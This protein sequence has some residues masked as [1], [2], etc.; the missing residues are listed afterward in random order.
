MDKDSLGIEAYEEA[1]VNMT[2]YN[3]PFYKD[4]VFYMHL[5]SGCRVHYDKDM[6]APAGVS[7]HND[8]YVLHLNPLEVIQEGV[9]TDTGEKVVITGFTKNMPLAHRIGILKHEMSHISNG[10]LIRVEDRD[11][12]DFNY[13]SD[14][15][16][17]QD[18]ERTHLP[19]YAIYPDNLFADSNVVWG[20]T[21][22]TYYDMIQKEKEDKPDQPNKNSKNSSNGDG[23]G[24]GDGDG[25][26]LVDDHDTWK[27]STG[28]S[29]LQKEITKKLVEDAAKQTTKNKGNL[30][31]NYSSMI[32]NLTINREIDWVK[33]LR[34]ITGNKKASIRKTIM[35]KDR[36]LPNFSWIK[37]RT[38]KRVFELAVV[39][40]V[41]GSM[42]ND[43]LVEVWGEVLSIC[44]TYKISVTLVQVDAQ[45]Y[46]PQE[47]NKNTKKIERKATGG[48]YL[49]PALDKLKER[50]IKYDALVVTTDGH[51]FNNDIDSFIECKVP[52]IWVVESSGKLMD[53]MNSGKMVGVKLKNKKSN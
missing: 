15:A 31:S 24:D 6:K 48:T 29:S 40:D 17:N 12:R 47:L 52:V 25:E 46:E 9:N 22:E 42:G 4:Y 45:A 21:A 49:S 37:G 34:R 19:E 10:H 44:D 41:S 20:Q 27:Q 13:A 33:V 53:E 18:I 2:V 8:H 7:F 5:L 38:K 43:A 23:D 28:D 30:P 16:M 3:S 26:F 11:F 35:R 36:R 14:C 50:N 51:L 39:S 32:D 1:I